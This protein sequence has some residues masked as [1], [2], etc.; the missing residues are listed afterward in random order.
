MTNLQLGT[1]QGADIFR[2]CDKDRKGRWRFCALEIDP[3]K[4]VE[5]PWP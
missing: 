3:T 5:T 4:N 1:I 2:F